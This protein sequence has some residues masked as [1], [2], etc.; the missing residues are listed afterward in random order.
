MPIVSY[1]SSKMYF[2]FLQFF[3]DL[4]ITTYTIHYQLS[5]W[6]IGASVNTVIYIHLRQPW[7]SFD[8]F[9]LLRGWQWQVTIDIYGCDFCGVNGSNGWSHS[10][11]VHR[12]QLVWGRWIHWPLWTW[13]RW[14]RA[15]TA[16]ITACTNSDLCANAFL[17]AV[18]MLNIKCT[19]LFKLWQILQYENITRC[20]F[21]GDVLFVSC[22]CQDHAARNVLWRIANADA[23]TKLEKT[24]IEWVRRV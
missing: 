8:G 9:P 12:P 18:K 23:V 11:S 14:R 15:V 5:R 7:M 24:R 21:V 10:G 6:N 16:A 4:N 2:L 22:L 13:L 17:D 20:V 3:Y 19:V 1:L